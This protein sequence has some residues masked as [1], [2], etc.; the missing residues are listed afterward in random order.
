MENKEFKPIKLSFNQYEYERAC[1]DA[2][3]KLL[4]LDHMLVWS[5]NNGVY[6][7][8]KDLMKNF[9]YSPIPTFKSEWYRINSSKIELKVNQDKLL[10]LCEVDIKELEALDE[11][12][13]KYD[14]LITIVDDKK[15]KLFKYA[16]SVSKEDFT[17]YTKDEKQNDKVVKLKKYLEALGEV[18]EITNVYPANIC[19][20]LSNIITYDVRDNKYIINHSMFS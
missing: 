16:S 4:A 5:A 20:G 6:I 15:S 12:V 14:A 7:K 11:K 8:S 18:A 19:S 3:L 2:E 10:E 9:L 17:I 13:R 1:K